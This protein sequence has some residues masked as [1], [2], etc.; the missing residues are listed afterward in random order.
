[1][2]LLLAVLLVAAQYLIADRSMLGVRHDWSSVN[3]KYA[4]RFEEASDNQRTARSFL[5]G[6]MIGHA[7]RRLDSKR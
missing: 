6:F 4:G 2:E 3:G 5:R 7:S 1:M